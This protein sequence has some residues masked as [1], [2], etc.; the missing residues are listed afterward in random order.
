MT[1]WRVGEA[2]ATVFD[3]DG[4]EAGRLTPGQVVVPGHVD[5]PG[6]L[7]AQ[8]AAQAKRR[9]GYADKQRRPL[10]DKAS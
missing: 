5:T 4:Q 1:T 9:S 3:P 7:A 10:E 6:S 2:G 8:H